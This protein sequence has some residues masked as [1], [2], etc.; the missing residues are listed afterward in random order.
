MDNN[1]TQRTTGRAKQP[2]KKRSACLVPVAV[3]A[4]LS[5]LFA[6]LSY[7]VTMKLNGT[8]EDTYREKLAPR[9]AKSI[10][11]ALNKYYEKRGVYPPY[12]TGGSRR[13]KAPS[14]VAIDWRPFDPLLEERLLRSYPRHNFKAKFRMLRADPRPVTYMRNAV[15]TGDNPLIDY[16]ILYLGDLIEQ[17]KQSRLDYP[18]SYRKAPDA[19]DERLKALENSLSYLKQGKPFL[20]PGGIV[21]AEDPRDNYSMMPAGLKSIFPQYLLGDAGYVGFFHQFGYVRGEDMVGLG[22]DT[23]SAFLWMYA[24][25]WH[26]AH[27][28][29]DVVN[30]ETGELKPDG[31]PDGIVLLYELRDGKVVK[32]TRAEDM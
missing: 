14:G 27:Q 18:D 11:T 29:L 17:E 24:D 19:S 28:G 26:G 22:L 8:S 13:E 10:S 3:F 12:L 32:T 30:A 2:E 1:A 21:R 7:T 9:F 16:Y 6:I 5:V 15:I 25:P 20:V 23:R 4:G 31:I